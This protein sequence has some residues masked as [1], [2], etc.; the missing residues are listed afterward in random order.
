[1][2]ATVLTTSMF[3]EPKFGENV[4]V[5]PNCVIGRPQLAPKNLIKRKIESNNKPVEVGD[6]TVIGCNVVIY[7]GVVIGKDCLIGDGA[8]IYANTV[9]GDRVVIGQQVNVSHDVKIGNDVRIMP[10]TL[11]VG[12]T[13][14]GNNVFIAPSVTMT[15]DNTAGGGGE[16]ESITIDDNVRIG[17]GVFI[18][19]GVNIGSNSFIGAGSGVT[20]DV[21]PNVLVMG[22]PAK[23]IRELADVEVHQ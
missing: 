8:I 16:L 7:E 9:I 5:F 17:S 10:F 11:V 13:V 3:P 20:K 4:T 21:P 12:F 22:T 1:M 23:V 14:I 15:N 6:N 18:L 19:P 2:S